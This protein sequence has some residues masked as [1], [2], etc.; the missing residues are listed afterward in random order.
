MKGPGK[1]IAAVSLAALMLASCGGGGGGG[2]SAPP[3]TVTPTPSPTPTPTPSAS[4]GL[5]SRQAFA[6]AVID[7]WY[8]FPND[9][10]TVNA[11][12]YGDVQSYIDALLAPARAQNKDRYFTYITSIA[13]EEAYYTSG[14]SAGLGV[15]LAYDPY[16]QV[17]VIAEA[18]EDAPALDAGIDRGA[19]ISAIGTSSGNMRSISSIVASQ[20][21]AGIIDALGPDTAGVTRVLRVTDASGARNVSVTKAE[22]DIDPISDR[23]GAKVIQSGGRSYGY[24]NLRT[25]I[26]SAAPQ[27]RAAFQDFRDKGITDVVIDLRYNGGGLVSVADL[28]GDLLGRDRST[29]DLF[30]QLKFRPEKAAEEDSQHFFTAQ[31]EA[32]APTRIAF[33][34]TLSTASASELVINGMLPYLGANMTLVGDNTYGKPVGQVA[35]DN[36]ECDDRM[37]V[38]AFA[39][40]NAD[41]QGDYY[42]GLASRI[43]NSCA[44]DDDLSLPLGDPRE[45]SVSAA[46][47]FLS[48][49]AC[50]T[51]IADTRSASADRRTGAPARGPDMLVPAKPTTAQRELPGLF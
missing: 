28:F 25:F 19:R 49:Q 38:I 29:S 4:C 3:V 37:R 31:P 47:G 30:S 26:N 2:S 40:A 43:P 13:E 12:S 33:I 51:R 24:V 27:L 42:N 9:V 34:G 5:S 18:Y 10:A 50:T 22:Y 15:R 32:I 39:L 14:A 6:K 35:L 17:V 21:T 23:Y 1:S 45:A 16:A 46:I 8:L 7:E 11:S 44:A 20:G 48:G 36:A 41:G